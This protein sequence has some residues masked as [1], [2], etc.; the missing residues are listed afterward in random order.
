MIAA[1]AVPSAHKS[2]VPMSLPSL[3]AFS[4]R[5]LELGDHLID[6]EAGRLLA[7]REVLEGSQELGHHRGRRQ[8][9]VVVVEEPVI[10]GVRRD[11]GPFEWVGA[12][13][14]SLGTRRATNGSAQICSVP[15][16]RCSM[17]TTFQLSKRRA[18]TSPSSEK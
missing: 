12:Q 5:V 4:E 14:N 1:R 18:S 9:D 10:V 13:V 2:R 16:A 15:V 7:G 3:T 6:R 8:R 11:V 17:N